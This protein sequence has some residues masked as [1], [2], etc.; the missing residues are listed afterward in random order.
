MF[1]SIGHFFATVYTAAV[2]AAPVVA[3]DLKKIEGTATVVETVSAAIPVYGPL[4]VTVEKAAYAALGELSG[5]LTAGGA[6]AS[7]KLTDAGLDINVIKTIEA[8]I[9]GVTASVKGL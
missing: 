6:A 7:V 8:L 5:V 9:A 3:A 1:K 4:A 2:K